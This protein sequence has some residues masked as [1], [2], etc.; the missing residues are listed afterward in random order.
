MGSFTDWRGIIPGALTS[1]RRFSSLSIGPLPS[2]GL[3]NAST[4]RPSRDFP[5]GTSTMAPVLFTTSP[6]LMSLSSPNIT[7]PTLSVSRLSAIP[8]IPPGNST[9]SPACTLSNPCTR[10]TPSP[11]DSTWPTSATSAS[12]PKLAICCFRIAE[13]S[14]APISIFKS[15]S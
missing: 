1:T 13:T 9:I 10:A 7:T 3:P 15:L 12:A 14:A 6:S 8:F 4:T 2:I 5:T 11:T